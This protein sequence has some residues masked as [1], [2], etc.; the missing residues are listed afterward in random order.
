VLVLVIVIVEGKLKLCLCI[1]VYKIW[2][3]SNEVS[4][5]TDES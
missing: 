1:M 3:Q 4:V 5:G 2:G